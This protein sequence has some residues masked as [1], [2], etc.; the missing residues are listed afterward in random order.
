MYKKILVPLDGS[1]LSECSLSHVMMVAT[2]CK[3]PEV[4]LFRVAEPLSPMVYAGE[5]DA[6]WIVQAE[7]KNKVQA[8]EYIEEMA[9]R[10]KKEGIAVQGVF[11]SGRA[12]EEIIDYAKKNQVDL[13]VMSTHG[14]SGVSRWAWGS[15]ADR[16][17]RHSPVPVLMVTSSGCRT[18]PSE[19][20]R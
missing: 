1:G 19:D 3:V 8:K 5:M 9:V 20:T 6:R 11:V 13:I 4:V 2:G 10:L 14:R 18:N 17:L 15:V 12:A 7:E 16:V